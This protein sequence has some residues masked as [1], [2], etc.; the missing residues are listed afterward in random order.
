MFWIQAAALRT[1]AGGT[2]GNVEK[3]LIT[4]VVEPLM[5]GVKFVNQSMNSTITM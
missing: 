1:R 4:S 5:F 2:K 3:L